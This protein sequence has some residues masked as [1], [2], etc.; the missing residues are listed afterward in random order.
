VELSCTTACTGV[1]KHNSVGKISVIVTST[2]VAVAVARSTCVLR[3]LVLHAN[4]LTLV[5]LFNAIFEAS[6]HVSVSESAL[7][8]ES[9][10][11]R[12]SRWCLND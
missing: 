12:V 10:V 7:I 6:A 2:E 4:L 8:A 11:A 3:R 9:L 5:L 1:Y